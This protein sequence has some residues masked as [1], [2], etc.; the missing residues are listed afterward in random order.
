MVVATE[1]AGSVVSIATTRAEPGS[2]VATV[3]KIL[4]WIIII[5][6]IVVVLSVVYIG[7]SLYAGY[8]LNPLDPSS[9]DNAIIAYI[10]AKW[11][12][13]DTGQSMGGAAWG[14]WWR[15]TPFGWIGSAL[16][17]G[18]SA[19]GRAGMVENAGKIKDAIYTFLKRGSGN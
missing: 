19:S 1:A 12:V 7:W 13:S 2:P 10:E 15:L 11:G 5:I 8:G 4:K 6:L 14:A 18:T 9:W 17:L 3:G 16:G